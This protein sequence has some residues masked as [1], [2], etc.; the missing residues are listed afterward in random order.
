M[1]V[2]GTA[3]SG[4]KCESRLAKLLFKIVHVFFCVLGDVKF[5]FDRR[6]DRVS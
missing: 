3:H 5:Y 6:Y 2:F 1:G 4:I